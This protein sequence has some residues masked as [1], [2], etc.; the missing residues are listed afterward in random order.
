MVEPMNIEFRDRFLSLWRKYFNNAGLPIIFYYA[1]ETPI[2]TSPARCIINGLSSVFSGESLACTG[3]TV[4]CSGGKRYLGFAEGIRPNFEYFLSTGIPGKMKGERYVKTPEM[5]RQIM[6]NT[7]PFKAPARYI[8]FK[9]WDTLEKTDKP[10]V[11]IFFATPDVLA[12]LFTLARYDETRI[13][14]VIAPFGSGCSTIV[15]TPYLENK[16]D[17]PRAVIGMF[18]PSA[19]IY[20]PAETLSFAVPYKKFEQMAGNMEESFLTTEAWTNV[21]ERI[22]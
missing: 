17:N 11:V 2:A 3:E 5:V 13:D 22:P 21:Q 4:G 18:D 9:R 19:R 1:D 7:P 12:G 20:V 15:Q 6:A 14:P 16:T 10:E 8:V